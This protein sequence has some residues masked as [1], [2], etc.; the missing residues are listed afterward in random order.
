VVELIGK[1][2]GPSRREWAPLTQTSLRLRNLWRVLENIRAAGTT[3]RVRVADETGLTGTTVHRLTAELR[4]RRLIVR[5]RTSASG[6]VGRPPSLFRFNGGIGHVIGI[7]VGNETTRAV[8]ADLDRNVR[9]R[10]QR[11]TAAIEG[12]LLFALED[13]VSE[14]QR[15]AAVPRDALVAIGVGVAA[16]TA[17]EGTIVRASMHHLWEGLQLGA[18]LRR[19]FECEVVVSQDDH[20]AALAELE[21]GACVGLRDALVVNLGK[22]MGA[23]IIADGSVYRGAHGAAGRLAWIPVSRATPRDPAL[24]APGDDPADAFAPL[25][26]LLTADGLIA[27]YRRLGGGAQVA[28]AV[29]VFR[30]DAA[31]DAMAGLA[32]DS[33]ADRL[34][35]LIG[36]SIAVMDPQRVVVGGGIS[37]SFE[38]LAP[39][40]VGRVA[41]IVA[42][43]PPIVASELGTDAVATGAIG[44]ATRL[45][46]SWLAARLGA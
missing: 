32:V 25:A 29:D 4:R 39:L 5:A 20:M 12:G 23:G 35:W 22:G 30:A 19:D 33:F 38:R 24:V 45:A 3:S 31:G 6:G 26:H 8:L 46:D 2:G 18:Q 40:L 10:E 7:D 28:G 1:V 21:V 9:A 15:A 42:V 17:I 44:A 14:L 11:P 43:P 13:M 37:G 41:E 27:E 36:T 34:G 16:V